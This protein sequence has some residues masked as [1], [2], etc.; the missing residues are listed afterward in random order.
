MTGDHYFGLCKL[1][2]DNSCLMQNSLILLVNKEGNNWIFSL[3]KAS[4]MLLYLRYNYS[5]SSSCYLEPEC[6]YSLS[7]CEV[8]QFYAELLLRPVDRFNYEEFMECWRQSVPEGIKTDI[9]YLR[10]IP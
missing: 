3:V 1:K 8:C 2:L 6:V 9:N 7:E 4:M 10:V 5:I